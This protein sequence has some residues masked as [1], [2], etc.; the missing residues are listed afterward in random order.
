[1][2]LSLTIFTIFGPCC[3]TTGFQKF[4]SAAETQCLLIRTQI[5][6]ARFVAGII[7]AVI[8][9][10]LLVDTELWSRASPTKQ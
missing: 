5:N 2:F 10:P 9:Q 4:N 8:N 1:M 7:M 3:M 6:I